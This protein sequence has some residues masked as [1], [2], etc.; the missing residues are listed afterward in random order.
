M[1][2]GIVL[3]VVI[4]I[5]V[6]LSTLALVA[7][8]LMTQEARITEHK[9]RRIRAFFTARAAMV[10]AL[11]DLRNGVSVGTINSTTVCLNRFR[12]T[13][14]V[15]TSHSGP[16]GTD[17]VNISVNYREFDPSCPVED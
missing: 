3:A 16:M 17:E 5:M 12:A 10:Q 6:V 13:I 4:G 7:L 9:I 15:D 11:E 2:K 8:Y 1:K 14:N